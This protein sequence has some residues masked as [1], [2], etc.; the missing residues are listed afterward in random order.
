MLLS[1]DMG[2]SAGYYSLNVYVFLLFNCLI[3]ILGFCNPNSTF[4]C[5]DGTCIPRHTLCDGF[6]DCP[7]KY[8]EDEQYG[9]CKLIGFICFHFIDL[10]DLILQIYFICFY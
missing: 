4:Q 10:F 8:H 7:G 3:F 6:R 1:E 9:C 5:Y 2:F